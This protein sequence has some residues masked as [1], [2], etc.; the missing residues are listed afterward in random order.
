MR[1]RMREWRDHKGLGDAARDAAGP[2]RA[3]AGWSRRSIQAGRAG[4]NRAMGAI[5]SAAS[6]ATAAAA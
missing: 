1:L 6:S 4:R 3:A 2:A 5:I